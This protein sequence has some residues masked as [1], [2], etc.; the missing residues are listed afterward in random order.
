VCPGFAIKITLTLYHASGIHPRA[1]QD[2][3]IL[4]SGPDKISIPFFHCAGKLPSSPADLK[5]PKPLEA[6]KSPEAS[7]KP[8]I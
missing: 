4:T 2:V 8:P 6:V 3:K 7:L 5:E 1:R